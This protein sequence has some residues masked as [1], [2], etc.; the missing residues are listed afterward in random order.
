MRLTARLALAI[1]MAVA[2]AYG[3]L[4]AARS[5]RAE[6]LAR[7]DTS[8]ALRAA[9]RVAPGNA[10]YHARLA[11]LDA[12]DD[13]DLRI[14]LVSNPWRTSWWIAQSVRQEQDGDV[15]GAERSLL[16]ANAVCQYYT[17]RWSLAAFYYRQG[18]K[19]GFVK[20]AKLALSSGYGPSE[21]LFQM[22]QRLEIPS[23]EILRSIVPRDPARIESYRSFL[24]QHGDLEASFAAASELIQAGTA[25][26]LAGVLA[27]CDALYLAGGIGP[28]V[29]LWNGA[30]QVGWM[31]LQTLDPAAGK[32]LA[33]PAFDERV[34]Q[35]FDWRRPNPPGVALSRSE[36]DGALR[37]DFSGYQPETC[38]LLS[39]YV[40]LLPGRRY[41]LDVRFRT[42]GIPPDSGLTWSIR[43]LPASQ[44]VAG[45]PLSAPSDDPVELV[46][47]FETP[48]KEVPMRL[49][50]SYARA[51]GSMRIE[52]KLSVQS[53][54]LTLIP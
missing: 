51:S 47:P 3:L 38:D 39:Q 40:P 8:V 41:Q 53:V 50:L 20:W 10:D 13:A 34:E 19:P 28:S 45:G 44:R 46:F 32:S 27:T 22:A 16:R 17:P 35:A 14:A 1:V 7:P 12:S 52:G 6:W 21:P 29:A 42:Q 31:K 4:V 11:T 24:L 43:T 25:A 23:G 49:L 5:A 37:F 2:A 26:D 36:P 48:P 15:T 18:D 30:I 54:Q 9:S 33:N